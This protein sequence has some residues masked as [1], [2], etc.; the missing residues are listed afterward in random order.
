MLLSLLSLLG[1]LVLLVLAADWLVDG[2]TAIAKRL[3]VSLFVVGLTVVAYGTSFPEFVVSLIASLK[4]SSGLAIGNV[5]GSN[6]AN[7]GL[8]MGLTALI[9]PFEVKDVRLFKM[10]LPLLSF[11]SL[12]VAWFF[13]Y[14]DGQLERIE[15]LI[16]LFFALLFTYL[17][18]KGPKPEKF[19]EESKAISW[20]MTL[21]KVTLGILGLLL[22]AH[23]MVQGGSEIARLWGIS[24]RLIGLTI[25][26]VGTS[27]PELAAS[28]AG[29]LKGHPGLALGN[30]VGSCFF[31]L[32]FVLG[33]A[34]VISPLGVAGF[35]EI[36]W[37]L[38]VML[39]L[40]LLMWVMLRTGRR[41]IRLEGALLFL[42]YVSFMGFLI[43]TGTR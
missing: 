31:N 11:V 24:E 9:A 20:P 35:S 41:I 42:S 36:R 14:M 32:S 2:S 25:V 27:L 3:G 43:L 17:S 5:L 16:L 34:A 40:T 29:A 28:V 37:D 18:V 6:I 26:A 23:F 22:G 10:E 33:G 8:V 4:G 12:L 38:G 21:F 15:G 39:S 7:I 19:K 1:G 13:F 30:V